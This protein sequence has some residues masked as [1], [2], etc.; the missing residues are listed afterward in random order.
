MTSG[1]HPLEP[2]VCTDCGRRYWSW[3][4][5]A[6]E[7]QGRPEPACSCPP[8]MFHDPLCELVTGRP[9]GVTG[10]ETG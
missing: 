9:A 10:K 3:G 8:G 2:K 4:A 7:C 5:H 6:E 1:A